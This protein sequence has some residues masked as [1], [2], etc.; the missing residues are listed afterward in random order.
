[1]GAEGCED[2]KLYLKIAGHYDF[3]AVPRV[4]VGYRIHTDSMSW[5]YRQMHHSY[6]LVLSE[7]R[8]RWPDLP[9]SIFRW[10]QAR[11]EAALGVRAVLLGNWLD[12]MKLFG[13]A[14]CRD[15]GLLYTLVDR[16]RRGP[17]SNDKLLYDEEI[18]FGNAPCRLRVSEPRGSMKKRSSLVSTIKV[19]RTDR[20]VASGAAPTALT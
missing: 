10:S 17:R 3:A 9:N 14:F 2:Y 8:N 13:K 19:Q 15:P 1:L 4:L 18:T 20:T 5:N 11:F 7:T 6:R 12:A 16:F